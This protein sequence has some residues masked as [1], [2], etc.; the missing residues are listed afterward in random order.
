MAIID[1]HSENLDDF[2]NL[3]SPIGNIASGM[4]SPIYRGQGDSGWH[5][6]PATFREDIIKKYRHMQSNYGNSEHVILF[7]YTLL[8]NFLYFCDEMGLIIPQDSE[9]FR[10]AMRFDEFSS[11]YSTITSEWPD[12]VYISFIAMAQH[13]G[14]PTRLLDWTRN[15]LVAAYF[16][17]SQALNSSSSPERL[18]LWVIESDRSTEHKKTLDFIS[19]PGSTSNNLAAQKGVFL[20]LRDQHGEGAHTLFD[21]KNKIDSLDKLF[22]KE[23]ATNTYKIT[24]PAKLAGELLIRCH[25][26][27]L[28]AATLFPG[29]DGAAKATLEFKLAKKSAGYL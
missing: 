26:F 7:E 28:S 21:P 9:S 10:N 13:H 19:V 27:G 25:K 2:W 24:L 17:A 22:D 3:I 4:N 14:V 1:I 16:S 23:T 6:T 12:K 8:I 11:R 5:L 18:A 29:F 20:L 15:P